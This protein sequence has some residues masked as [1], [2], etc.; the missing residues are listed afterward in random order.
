[1]HSR[2][3][4]GLPFFPVLLA[5]IGLV[6]CTSDQLPEPTIQDCTDLGVVTYEK[7]IRF[8]IDESCA[9][10]GC[11]LD[12]SPGNF[13]SYAGLLPYLESNIFRQRV[14]LQRADPTF[15]MPPDNVPDG[16]A[17]DLTEG[18]ILMIECWLDAGFPEN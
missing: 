3:F 13:T 16:K 6:A 4:R 15:G 11:H 10:S 12:S 7:D 17:Q 8:I 14:I 9:Y 1:M 2:T 18:Q 5:I